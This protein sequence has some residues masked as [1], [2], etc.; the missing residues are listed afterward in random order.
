MS[1]HGTTSRYTN[2]YCRCTE[3]REAWRVYRSGYIARL[4]ASVGA[5]GLPL[6]HGT[7][8]SYNNYGCRCDD[9]RA[10]AS[11]SARHRRL[12]RKAAR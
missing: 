3:C 12:A 4:R 2:D 1:P 10:A 9:C 7:E 5:G 6:K 11:D 8:N